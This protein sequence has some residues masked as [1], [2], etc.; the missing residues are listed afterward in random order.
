MNSQKLVIL[1][2]GDRGTALLKQMLELSERGVSVVGVFHSSEDT[3]GVRIAEKAGIKNL[4]LDEVVA[5]GNSLDI[6]FDMTGDRDTRVELRK[7]LFSSNNQHTVIAPECVAQLM[8]TMIGGESPA[9]SGASG[10]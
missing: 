9:M 5:L 10:Y 7:I 4:S 8:Y 2:L 6:I 3:E 1:G